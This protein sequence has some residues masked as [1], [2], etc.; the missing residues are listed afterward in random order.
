MVASNFRELVD[1]VCH[2]IEDEDY[3]YALGQ[4]SQQRFRREFMPAR[5]G[6]DY[7]DFLRLLR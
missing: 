2:V 6:S 5:L 1:I 7:L 4:S 3:R